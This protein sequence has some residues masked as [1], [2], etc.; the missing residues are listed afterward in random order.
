MRVSLNAVW[1]PNCWAWDCFLHGDEIRWKLSKEKNKLRRLPAGCDPF[2]HT[3]YK[4]WRRCQMSPLC[5][6]F[7]RDKCWWESK[8]DCCMDQMKVKK[9]APSCIIASEKP[10]SS[11]SVSS[12]PRPRARIFLFLFIFPVYCNHA[13]LSCR[14]SSHTKPPS[15]PHPRFFFFS[16]WGFKRPER[17]KGFY[18]RAHLRLLGRDSNISSLI[19]NR[20]WKGP[21]MLCFGRCIWSLV[22]LE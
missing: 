5:V 14:F 18:F 17:I 6:N 19:K 3:F 21:I 10:L 12:I 20:P 2:S 16:L 13:I 15:L 4:T 11:P 8:Q 7:T 22:L 1:Q 9:I